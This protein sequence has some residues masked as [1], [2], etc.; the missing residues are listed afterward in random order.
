MCG[1]QFLPLRDDAQPR[2]HSGRR[3]SPLPPAAGD[4]REHVGHRPHR[5]HEAGTA[6]P[7]GHCRL[8]TPNRASLAN[9]NRVASDMTEG[10]AGRIMGKASSQKKKRRQG[11]GA[12]T[13]KVSGSIADR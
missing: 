7:G 13:A 2:M 10:I 5:L 12:S 1:N 6:P 4:A 8:A 3:G 11:T 9:R